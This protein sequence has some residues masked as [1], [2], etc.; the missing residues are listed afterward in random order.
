MS[1]LNRLRLVDLAPP[2]YE[3]LQHEAEHRAE[4]AEAGKVDVVPR[5]SEETKRQREAVIP[6]LQERMKEAM[7]QARGIMS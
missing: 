4:D 2:D 1:D 5:E 6:R 3:A 7:E